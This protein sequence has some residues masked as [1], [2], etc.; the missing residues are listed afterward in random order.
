M[1]TREEGEVGRVACGCLWW[2]SVGSFEGLI[3]RF[4]DSCQYQSSAF[5]KSDKFDILSIIT[6]ETSQSY[7][8][9][10]STVTT[11]SAAL[12]TFQG[13][14]PTGVFEVAAG[15][16]DS[17][18]FCGTGSGVREE[19]ERARLFNHLRLRHHCPPIVSVK[20]RIGSSTTKLSG[21]MRG[22][23]NLHFHH[24]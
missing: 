9:L 15:F 4:P 3:R 8:I 6:T 7:L 16:A 17:T 12:D 1:A 14:W 5:T 19:G 23:S 13:S 10:F 20:Q 2:P 11:S 18:V 21:G 22:D 24:S